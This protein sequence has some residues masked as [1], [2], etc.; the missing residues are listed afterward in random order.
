MKN[1]LYILMLSM[2]YAGQ[3]KAN[4][5]DS[6]LNTL[7]QQK[8]EDTNKVKTFIQLI[9][10]YSDNYFDSSLYYIKA[11]EKLTKKLNTTDFDFTLNTAY[12][13]YYYNQNNYQSTISYLQKCKQIATKQNDKLLLSKVLNNLSATYSHFGQHRLAIEYGLTAL[14]SAIELNDTINLSNRY[15]T[16]CRIYHDLR[17][18]PKSIEYGKM[19][20][21]YGERYK[22]ANGTIISYNNVASSYSGLFMLDSS[23]Y[24]QLQALHLALKNNNVFY[25][26]ASLI[27]LSM[28]DFRT[29]KL[30][31]IKSYSQQLN[32]LINDYDLKNDKS[33]LA[34]QTIV[35]SLEFLAENKIN[36]AKTELEKGID[37]AKVE[38]NNDALLNVYEM[39]SKIEYLRHNISDAE[40][41]YFKADSIRQTIYAS[42]LNN[43]TLDLNTKYETQKKQNEIVKQKH[44]IKNQKIWIV[45]LI[46]STIIL[47]TLSFFIFRYFKQKNTILEK[48]RIIQ[49]QQIYEL[50]KEKQLQA[51]EA[52]LKG[53]EEERSRIAKDLHDGLGGLLSGVKYSLNNMK[54]NVIL[55][56]DNA[57]SFARNIDMLDT[58]IQ[59]LRRIAHS[60]MPEN[61][62]KF[63]LDT[64]LKDYCDAITKTNVLRINYSSFQMENFKAD[65]SESVIVYRV[66]QELINNT[67]KHANAS[68]LLVQLSKD[69][70]T[71]YIT[72][73]DNGKGFDTAD[74]QHFKGAGWTNIHNRINYLKGKIDVQSS[75]AEGTSVNIEIPLA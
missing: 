23:K 26:Y 58:G 1:L 25:I 50:E 38:G 74:I 61:L 33:I 40:K 57:A 5:L 63:G 20:I 73:E 51:T 44:E 56:A 36:D 72:V 13:E 64:A 17:D 71:L 67:I 35:N 49:Q 11:A 41:Y 4:E 9:D 34:H 32:D 66:I 68:E 42:E 29:G 18:Y 65:S 43:F 27:N 62:V 39:L 54:E 69:G 22:H 31:T 8:K 2:L 70:N 47:I 19:G 37:Y 46:V 48:E 7:K 14:N 28:N 30:S 10:Y 55:S 52:I 75:A 45:I 59:E 16:V 24:Y 12:A 21:K 53:Q 6:L 3:S 60:M 15:A